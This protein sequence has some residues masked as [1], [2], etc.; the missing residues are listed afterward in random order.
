MT[1]KEFFNIGL[2][3]WTAFAVVGTPVTKE[4]AME[5]LIRTD[6]LCFSTNDREFEKQL[7]EYLF[8]LKIFLKLSPLNIIVGP[9]FF[10]TKG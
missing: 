3:K 7:N 4:Q 6:S 8:N 5:I 2:P 9:N 10:F 1:K